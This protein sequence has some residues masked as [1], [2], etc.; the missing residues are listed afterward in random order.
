MLFAFEK[1]ENIDD[2]AERSRLMTVVII[3]GGPTGVELAGAFTELV[4]HVLD[5]DFR[6]IEPRKAT[7]ILLE[8]A[9]RILSHLP[10][11]L[12]ESA[13]RQ[14]AGLGTVIRTSTMQERH[15]ERGG[16]TRRRRN[17]PQSEKHHLGR[18]SFAAALTEKLG[19]NPAAP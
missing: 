14:L 2:P 13:T 11:D 17:H 10:E 6:R 1:A 15:P 16:G 5:G 12:S 7:I 8:G 9:P 18:R 4:S 3:G 19:G